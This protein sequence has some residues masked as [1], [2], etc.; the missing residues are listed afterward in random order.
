VLFV[1]FFIVFGVFFV[2]VL[3]LIVVSAAKRY[4]AA[5]R[6]GLD[7]FAA[8][9]QLMGRAANSAALAPERTTAERLAEIDA[10]R[11]A[12]T[13]NAAE[14]EAARARIISTL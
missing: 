4:N 5:K 13:I 1:V 8:D 3:V 11:A 9:V 10:L 7:P 6:A 12:G 2:A 14:H